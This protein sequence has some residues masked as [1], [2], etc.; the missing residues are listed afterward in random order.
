MLLAV[1]GEVVLYGLRNML[2]NLRIQFLD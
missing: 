2:Q 1:G